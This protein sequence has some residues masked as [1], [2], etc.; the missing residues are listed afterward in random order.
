MSTLKPQKRVPALQPLSR[1]H[2]QA[3]LLCWKIKTGLAKGIPAER[4]YAYAA[5]FHT[6]HLLPHFEVEEK[7]L[8]PVLGMEN[9]LVQQAIE[10]HRALAQLF[11]E[12]KGSIAILAQVQEH[13]E[14]HIRFEERVLF[15]EIQAAA[16]QAQLAQLQEIHQGT[17]F[18]DNT[19][20]AF[21]V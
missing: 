19:T 12:P 21:W 16:T 18:V 14:K 17:P 5:W 15:N 8:F 10:E 1:E 2:H 6:A 3:L 13:L 7:Y 9:K 11:C 4:V 20:D